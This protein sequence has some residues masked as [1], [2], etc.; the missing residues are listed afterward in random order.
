MENFEFKLSVALAVFNEESNLGDCLESIK[1]IAEEIVIVDGGSKDRTVSIAERYGA[2]VIHSDNPAVFH[3]NKQK[4]LD[5][6]RGEWILQLDADERV[7]KELADEILKVVQMSAMNLRGYVVHDDKKRTLFERHEEA[8]RARD[9]AIGNDTGEVAAFFVPRS[10]YF[11]GTFLKYGGAYPDGTIRLVKNGK[12]KF[13]LKDVHDQMMIDGTVRWLEHD[14]LHQADPEFSR[15]LT[16]SNRYTSLQASQWIDSVKNN[17]VE[18]AAPKSSIQIL[19]GMGFVEE[20]RWMLWEPVK[21]FMKIY[22]RHKAFKDGFPGFVW[23]MYS[24]LHV[25]SSYVKFWE[26][27]KNL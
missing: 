27:C 15:Y 23:A 12:A 16:R 5:A 2:H 11:L 10:N 26:K 3:I 1:H 13:A 21:T 19:P 14:L 18:D 24:G 7:S 9:G 8:M 4:A 22:F 20:V 6:C 17:K 25:A